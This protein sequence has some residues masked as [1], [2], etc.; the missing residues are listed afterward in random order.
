[1]RSH[2]QRR[3][4]MVSIAFAMLLTVAAGLSLAGEHIGPQVRHH[5]PAVQ[6][7]SSGDSQNKRRDGAAFA[8]VRG[9]DTAGTGD[10][11]R[12]RP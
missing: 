11:G 6:A 1:M 10:A 3:G 7:D 12:P 9:T 5:R 8:T 4:I 2:A